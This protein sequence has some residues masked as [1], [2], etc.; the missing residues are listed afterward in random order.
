MITKPKKNDRGT[1][2]HITFYGQLDELLCALQKTKHYVYCFHDMDEVDYHYHVI[3]QYYNARTCSAVMRD[4]IS[5]SNCFVEVVYGLCGLFDYLTHENETDKYHYS[6]D[7]LKS[8]LLSYW[9]GK[10][11]DNEKKSKEDEIECFCDDLMDYCRGMIKLKTMAI[12]YG[13]DFI[14]NYTTYR[15]FGYSLCSEVEKDYYI[16]NKIK[17]ESLNNDEDLL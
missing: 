1:L 2:F 11:K 15:D 16:K 8:D 14:K 9:V 4:F 10:C 13:K 17:M 5:R 3:A 7:R 12:R 6:R